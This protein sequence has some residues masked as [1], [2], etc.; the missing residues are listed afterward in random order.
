MLITYQNEYYDITFLIYLYKK[1]KNIKL[2]I[3]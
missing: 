2:R 1:I 3:I